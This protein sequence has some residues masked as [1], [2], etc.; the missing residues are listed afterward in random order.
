MT[1]PDAIRSARPDLTADLMRRTG[2]DDAMLGRLVHGFYDRVRRDPLLG[3]IFAERI[4][5]WTPH[6]DQMVEFW[7][8]VALMTGRYHGAPMPKH[9]P[10]PVE[11]GTLRPLAGSVPA[12]R[13]RG[14]PARRCG[15]GHRT[16]RTDRVLHPHEHP[17]RA[18]PV[19]P[20]GSA[21]PPVRKA[22][23]T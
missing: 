6:L 7:S 16:G 15:L 19:W 18:G 20:R 5:D 4:T 8:S 12:D 14:L 13:A 22:N 11:A 3:P 21:A 10:L 9:L 23:P 1:A 17:G 2:L